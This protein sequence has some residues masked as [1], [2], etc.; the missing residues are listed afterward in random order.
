MQRPR[1][2]LLLAVVVVL[3]AASLILSRNCPSAGFALSRQ[4]RA[5][6]RLK[7]RTVMPQDVDFNP[8]VSL[9]ELLKPG[10]DSSRWST[11]KV[12]R[13]EAYV[14]DVANARPEAANC[15]LPC[16]RANHILVGTGQVLPKTNRLFSRL[17]QTYESRPLDKDRIGQKPLCDDSCWATGVN[18]RAGCFSMWATRTTRLRRFLRLSQFSNLCNRRNLWILAL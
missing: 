15:F 14:I 17:R 11:Q 4:A 3:T 6:H 2:L 5:L 8:Q 10:D 9:S 13:I 12:A 7:N 1:I 18:L 16:R